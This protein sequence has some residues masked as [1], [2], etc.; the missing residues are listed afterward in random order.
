MNDTAVPGR[1]DALLRATATALGKAGIEPRWTEARL[2]FELAG[3]D[4]MALIHAPSRFLSAEED[5]IIREALAKRLQGVP[6]ARLRGTKDFAGAT[7]ALSAET[8]EPRDDTETLIEAVSPFLAARP[9]SRLIDIGTGTGIIAIT[10]LRRFPGVQAVATDISADALA[11]AAINGTRLGVADRLQ[12]RQGDLFAGAGGRFDLVI[13]NPP[14]IPSAHLSDLAREVRD[15][16]PTAALDGGADGLDFYRRIADEAP[17]RL[18]VG[19]IIA[20]E[21]GHDQ[22]DAVPGIFGR[23]GFACLALHRDLG[24]RPRALLFNR[25]QPIDTAG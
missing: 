10:L 3:L 21:I 22:G 24:G 13:S 5:A 23:A 2:I 4:R 8:L 1:V 14:Y 11:T 9:E 25:P 7:F 18:A 15:H 6:V 12:I 19:G 17:P 16:D 20:V